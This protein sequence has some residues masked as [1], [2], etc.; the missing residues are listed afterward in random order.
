MKPVIQEEITG[1][2]IASSAAI[3]GLSYE[4]AKQVANRLGIYAEDKSL[5]SSTAHIRTLINEL[6]FALSEKEYPF[7][8]W[9]NLPDCALL[10]IKW[11]IEAG[12]PFWHWVVFVR[13]GGKE[14]VLDS[15]KALTNNV[16]TD[17]WRM[18]PK[19]YIEVYK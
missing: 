8:G 11:H 4:R 6:G 9:E 2:A 3:A 10:S 7:E 13:E 19:W 17:F 15:K 16:R 12:K 18:N 14:F 1:C 5:W